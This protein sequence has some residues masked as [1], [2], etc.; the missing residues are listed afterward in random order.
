MSTIDLKAR[1]D[2]FKCH[3]NVWIDLIK[4]KLKFVKCLFSIFFC[5]TW[6]F[7]NVYFC[8]KW[9]LYE[10]VVVKMLKLRFQIKYKIKHSPFV[11]LFYVKTLDI[12]GP[13]D[14]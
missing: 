9:A 5:K 12:I 6:F 7:E 8:Y 10:I 4:T 1:F 2:R 14:N 11:K 13:G 3:L